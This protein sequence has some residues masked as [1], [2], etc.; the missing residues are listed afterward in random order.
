M[1]LWYVLHSSTRMHNNIQHQEFDD[2]RD[3]EDAIK[4]LDGTDLDGARIVVEMCHG[5]GRRERK[6]SEECFNCGG[7]GHW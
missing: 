3:A 4:D 2:E 1:R 7:V 6:G 5:G